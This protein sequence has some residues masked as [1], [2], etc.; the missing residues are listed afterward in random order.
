MTTLILIRHGRTT[1]NAEGRWQ[2]QANP[3]L[4]ETGLQQAAALAEYLKSEPI[5]A[6]Y[7][8]PQTRARQT[9][10]ALA[11]ALKLPITFDSRL[12]E[13]NIG[14]WEGLTLA[15]VHERFPNVYHPEWWINGAPGGENHRDLTA[16]ASAAF[17]EIVAAHSDETVAVVSHG[18]TL[19]AYL[20][21]LLQIAPGQHV[22][23]RFQNTSLA[24]VTV[25]PR[26]V[27]L[28]S[29]GEAPHLNGRP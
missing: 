13:R 8:S 11:A 15:E 29:L 16:R 25:T 19:N 4:D 21:N 23:F 12:A 18:G 5:I 10:E 9:A 22:T 28:I 3:P 24:R 7:S 17:G 1:W 20:F 2:G 14:V 6:L 26:Q 27:H